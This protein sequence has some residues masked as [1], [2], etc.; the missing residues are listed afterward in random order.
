M[1]QRERI[2][3]DVPPVS[4]IA[5][6]DGPLVTKELAMT[7]KYTGRCA[8]GAVKFDS[9]TNPTFVAAEHAQLNGQL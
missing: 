1:Q 9:D 7:K 4:G 2:S 5:S 6:T 8:C 3:V